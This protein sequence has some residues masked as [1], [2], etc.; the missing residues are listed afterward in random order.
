MY[1][2]HSI[3]ERTIICVYDADVIYLQPAQLQL[4][5]QWGCMS[6]LNALHR[7]TLINMCSLE[8]QDSIVQNVLRGATPQCST[9][10]PINLSW[11]RN[12]C[13]ALQLLAV[14]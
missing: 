8:V 7:S 12:L 10:L 2:W 5:E 14:V 1:R 13:T 4:P 9:L 11:P 3:W 6:V